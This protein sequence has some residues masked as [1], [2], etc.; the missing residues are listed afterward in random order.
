MNKLV[1]LL[2]THKLKVII[3]GLALLIV[4]NELFLK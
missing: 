4:V 2:K 3:G 1:E